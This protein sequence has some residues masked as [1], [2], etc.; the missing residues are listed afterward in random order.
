M[1]TVIINGVEFS[2]E[3]K[4]LNHCRKIQSVVYHNGIL[5]KTYEIYK[6]HY[7]H[8][9]YNDTYWLEQFTNDFS[10]IQSINSIKEC[11]D[12]IDMRCDCGGLE[13]KDLCAFAFQYFI[14]KNYD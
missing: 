8:E 7:E 6:D 14:D 3:Q 11:V 1:K 9:N 10:T 12:F 5:V 4:N 13:D 2:F